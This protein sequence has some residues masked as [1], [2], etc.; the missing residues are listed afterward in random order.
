MS[1]TAS[2]R[3]NASTSSSSASRDQGDQSR[4]NPPSEGEEFIEARPDRAPT[5]DEESAAERAARDVDV[6]EV[7]SHYEEMTEL[8]ANVKGEGQVEPS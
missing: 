3:D 4:Q 7:G 6:A 8:G 5:P 1:D 2:N